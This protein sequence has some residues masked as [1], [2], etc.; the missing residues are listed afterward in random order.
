MPPFQRLL[1]RKRHLVRALYP[2]GPQS[3]TLSFTTLRPIGV[4]G[5]NM[6]LPP[7]PVAN[8]RISRNISLNTH[9]YMESI[10]FFFDENW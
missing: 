5:A 7:P 2:S 1:L 9:Y 10:N 4:Y 6:M 3:Y 8:M